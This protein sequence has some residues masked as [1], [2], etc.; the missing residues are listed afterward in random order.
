M[1]K[2]RTSLTVIPVSLHICKNM[3]IYIYVCVLIY[4][5]QPDTHTCIGT[6]IYTC[7]Y[8]YM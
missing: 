7:I 3:C 1:G 8:M 2:E 6:D 5:V 4:G